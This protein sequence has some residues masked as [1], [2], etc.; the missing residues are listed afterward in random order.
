MTTLKKF[1]SVENGAVDSDSP[2]EPIGPDGRRDTTTLLIFA[3]GW[4]FLIT[5]LLTGGALGTGLPFWPDLIIATSIGNSVS[6]IIGALI[7]YMGY[8]SGC[9]SGLLYRFTYGRLGAVFPVLFLAVLTLGWQAIIVGAFSFAFVQ[10]FSHPAFYVVAILAGTLFTLTTYYGIKGLEL[11]ALP[12]ILIL[13]AVGL[14]AIY[15]NIDKVG[16]LEAF[17]SVSREKSGLAALPM[18]KAINLVI[19]AWI[20]GSI[21]MAE[22]TRFAKN[23]WVA[24]AIPFIVLMFAQWFL[25]VIGALGV[26]VSGTADFTTYLRGQGAIIGGI[27]LIGM[28]FAL[29]T[30]G[31][32]NLYLPVIQTASVFHVNKRAMVIVCGAISTVV[33]LG[34]YQNF[35]TWLD[36]VSNLVPPLIGPVIVDY[37]LL[38]NRHYDAADLKSLTPWK[39]PALLAY[40]VGASSTYMAPDWI[41]PSLMGLGVAMLVYFCLMRWRWLA[42]KIR[43]DRP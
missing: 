10:D 7:G 29:W 24:I 14:L 17:L 31:N 38:R 27:G 11:V 20:V 25:Q 18:E 32:A 23:A 8:Q 22:Y 37:Y 36:I 5:G 15:V 16:G 40:L 13:V 4:G 9:N 1:F 28:A 43:E 26:V 21:V 19:G 33:G 30:T 3:F 34:L 39:F 2:F 12:A 42:D 41:I 6:F 35:L